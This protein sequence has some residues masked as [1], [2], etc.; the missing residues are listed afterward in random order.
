[1]EQERSG[2]LGQV[3]GTQCSLADR[4]L[5]LLAAPFSI[6]RRMTMKALG[7]ETGLF[8][9]ERSHST[10]LLQSL[11]VKH[12]LVVDSE[13]VACGSVFGDSN[14]SLFSQRSLS[15]MGLI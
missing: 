8:P 13:R 4:M 2:Y 6:L 12:S 9:L 3:S 15:L 5:I 10:T 11:D 1:M 7:K 14:V